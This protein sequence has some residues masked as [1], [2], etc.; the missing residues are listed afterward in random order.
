MAREGPKGPELTVARVIYTRPNM[1]CSRWVVLYPE[2][3]ASTEY[4]N[5]VYTIDA[6]LSRREDCHPDRDAAKAYFEVAY[7]SRA[8]EIAGRLAQQMGVALRI[9]P[10]PDPPLLTHEEVRRGIERTCRLRARIEDRDIKLPT[11]KLVGWSLPV[12][13]IAGSAG[14]ARTRR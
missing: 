2:T 4:E 8:V 1:S 6:L 11:W 9:V 3:D 12:I 14:P 5:L 13:E 10:A 7:G